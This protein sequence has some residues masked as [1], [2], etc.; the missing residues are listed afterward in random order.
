MSCFSSSILYKCIL[1]TMFNVNLR[2]LLMQLPFLKGKFTAKTA[3]LQVT[4]PNTSNT[5]D[6]E[7]TATIVIKNIIYH[8]SQEECK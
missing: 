8:Q 4:S 2:Y 6:V 1:K 3:T 5:K 7:W